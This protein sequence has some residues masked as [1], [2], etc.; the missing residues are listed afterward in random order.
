MGGRIGTPVVSVR[1]SLEP[2]GS[3]SWAIVLSALALG[4][5]ACTLVVSPGYSVQR[6]NV[7]FVAMFV[8]FWL[9]AA[10]AIVLRLVIV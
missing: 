9:L 6:R 4:M 8:G 7:P 3:A 10:P 1:T 2:V 5:L